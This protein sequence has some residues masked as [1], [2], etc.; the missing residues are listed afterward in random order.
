MKNIFFLC[1][2]LASVA[3]QAQQINNNWNNE[4]NKSLGSFAD[5]SGQVGSTECLSY[6]GASLKTV[7]QLDDFYSESL[8]RYLLINEIYDLLE[9]N[10]NWKLLG[11]GYEQEALTACQELANQNKAVVAVMKGE[12][13][14]HMAL[15]LP[16][17]LKYSGTW[18]LNVPNS[19]SFF[20]HQVD[21]SFVGKKLSY[22]FTPRDMGY[23][24]LYARQY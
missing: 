17:D 21:D 10:E 15:I 3:V 6:A 1:L 19:A 23:V 14:G 24:K 12:E 22:A 9:K 4:L 16:G 11:K 20:T 5:C 8:G 18:N 2:M 7:Y 13:Y